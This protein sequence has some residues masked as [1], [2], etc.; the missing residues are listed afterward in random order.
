MEENENDESGNNTTVEIR[1]VSENS[2][3]NELS[4][5]ETRYDTNQGN[6]I[7][8]QL[9]SL[10]TAGIDPTKNKVSTYLLI[11]INL[12]VAPKAGYSPHLEITKLKLIF[13]LIL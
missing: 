6:D 10:D 2:D 4:T 12:L 11:F 7:T 1:E 9:Q 8:R 5:P 13:F 3:R